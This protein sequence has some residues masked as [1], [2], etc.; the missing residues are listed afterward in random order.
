MS[1]APLVDAATLRDAGR[2]PAMPCRVA[3]DDGR[4]IELLRALRVLPGKR[5][6]AAARLD[7]QTVLAKLFIADA[8]ERHLRRERD[9]IQALLAAGIDTPEIVT[10]A[11]L[12]GGGQLLATRFLPDA[13]SLADRWAATPRP[14]GDADAIALLAP[15]LAL[16]AHMH[17]AGLTQTDLHLGNFLLDGGRLLIIDGDAVERQD[18]PLTAQ[19]ATANLAILLAQLPPAWDAHAA[20]LLG[21]Y[22]DAGGS[23]EA[24]GLQT[25]IDKVRHWRLDDLLDKSLRDCSLFAVRRSA[26]RFET[27][28]RNEAATLAPLLADL[29]GAMAR[30][31]LLK[32]GRTVTVAKLVVGG[33]TL[34]VKRYNIKG[35]GHGLSRLWRPSRAWHSW[36]AAH[37]LRFL[38]IDTPRPLA[39]VEERLG[40]LRRRAW[41][42]SEWCDGEALGRA[43]NADHAPPPALATALRNTF[44]TLARERIHHGDLKASNLLWN[45]GRLWLIDLDATTA[46]RSPTAFARAWSRDRARLLRNWPPG[47]VL[48]RWLDTHLPR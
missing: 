22:R 20:A 2:E 46:H 5:V 27:V 37:R 28:V 16:L 43:L 29:D 6:V 10:E 33:R 47:S 45:T 39:M 48:V 24:A 4:E 3:L 9:G 7:G 38:G 44:D 42:I 23:I 15:A 30:G 17:A 18:R 1:T 8:A 14:P 21:A 32:D 26:A 41:L 36:L 11:A 40:P 35:L 19:H 13:V 31:S 25:A 34:V 12:P